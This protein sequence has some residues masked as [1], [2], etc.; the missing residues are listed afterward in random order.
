MNFLKLLLTL[1]GLVSLL[2]ITAPSGDGVSTTVEPGPK[3][4]IK[5]ELHEVAP[6][7]PSNSLDACTGECPPDC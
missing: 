6:A 5:I 2:S 1:G 7:T 3:E 4:E